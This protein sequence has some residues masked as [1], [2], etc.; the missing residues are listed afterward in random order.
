MRRDHLCAARR[1]AH[2]PDWRRRQ[3]PHSEPA[4]P[5]VLPPAS[6]PAYAL[7]GCGR[8]LVLR[9]FASAEEVSALLSKAMRHYERGEL[10]PNP[11]GPSR[12]FAKVDE[13]LATFARCTALAS[14]AALGASTVA[15][16]EAPS[17]RDPFRVRPRITAV[18][19]A[20]P[21]LEGT[22]LRVTGMSLDRVGRTPSLHVEAF[23]ADLVLLGSFTAQGGAE[24]PLR[25]D[26]RLQRGVGGT[27]EVHRQV[28][29]LVEQGQPLGARRLAHL[30]RRDGRQ[31]K[32]HE[33]HDQSPWGRRRWEARRW[34][35]RKG[36]DGGGAVRDPRRRGVLRPGARRRR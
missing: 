15:C 13:A 32:R 33:D 22:V 11:C 25:V 26:L 34:R 23:G 10:R 4:P 20:T 9:R 14:L 36:E 17:T 21:V 8:W 12:F 5:P 3:L 19:A 6:P 16:G 1:D 27:P 7:D 2:R 24:A 30:R 31:R 35:G 18:E 29:L 28:A